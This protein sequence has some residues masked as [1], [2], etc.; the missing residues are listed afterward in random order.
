MFE[1]N[2]IN[3]N[4]GGI[5]C[6]ETPLSGYN[7][8]NA[9]KLNKGC[10]FSQAE[11]DLFGLNGLLPHQVETLEQQVARMYVQYHEHSTNLSK[12]IHLNV[13]HDYNETLFYKLVSEHLEEMLPIIYTPTVGEAVQR[14]SL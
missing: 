12:N 13:L 10:A 5:A 8:L 14:F 11:R 7:L 1:F 9:S 6:I 3:N 2:I 4:E